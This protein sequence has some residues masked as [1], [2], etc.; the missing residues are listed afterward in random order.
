DL[1]N[2]ESGSTSIPYKEAQEQWYP[3]LTGPLT[4]N[5]IIYLGTFLALIGI[6]ARSIGIRIEKPVL[7]T[8]ARY[9]IQAALVLFW[10]SLGLLAVYFL[11][12]QSSSKG[13]DFFESIGSVLVILGS[14]TLIPVSSPYDFNS[15][16]G[17]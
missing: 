2:S 14:L 17:K 12:I 10:I 5:L 7:E 16:K 9:S 15:A 3:F 11:G 4:P 6:I 13:I 8:R 1:A